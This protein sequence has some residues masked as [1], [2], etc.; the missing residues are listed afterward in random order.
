[1]YNP[2]TTGTQIAHGPMIGIIAAMI[3]KNVSNRELETP[4][5]K[6]LIP[7]RIPVMSPVINLPNTTE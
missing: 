2:T 5:K 4:A 1:M 3:A 6:K 7:V